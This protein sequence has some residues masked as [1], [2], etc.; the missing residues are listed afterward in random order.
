MDE[1]YR[2]IRTILGQLQAVNHTAPDKPVG[3]CYL[4]SPEGLCGG[5]VWIDDAAGHAHCGRCRAAWD[6]PQIAALK[7]ELDKIKAE[8]ARPKMSDGRRMLTAVE[9]SNKHKISVNAVRIRLS[10]IGAKAVQ[11]HYDPDVLEQK[12]KAIA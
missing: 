6:G 9:L 1:C 8:A 7:Y 10:R 2:D 4:P 11:G 5:P 3:R 12:G